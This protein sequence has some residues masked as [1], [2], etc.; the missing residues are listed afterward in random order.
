[1]NVCMYARMHVCMHVC[2]YTAPKTTVGSVPCA[3]MLV[4]YTPSGNNSGVNR[5]HRVALVRRTVRTE[6]RSAS[7]RDG[8]AA[9]DANRWRRLQEQNDRICEMVGTA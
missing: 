2:M 5:T 8:L 6:L 1:M 7:D 3:C 9:V 4:I